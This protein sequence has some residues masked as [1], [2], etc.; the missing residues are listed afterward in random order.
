MRWKLTW[1]GG[2]I[3]LGRTRHLLVVLAGAPRP[4]DAWPVS[5]RGT[6]PPRPDHNAFTAFRLMAAAHIADGAASANA[7]AERAWRTTIRHYDLSADSDLNPWALLAEGT[8]GQCM[9]TAAFVEAVVDILGFEGG[10]ISY[11]YPT[12]RRP[13]NPALTAIPNPHLPGAFTVEAADYDVRGQ[14][15]TVTGVA[16]PRAG[17]HSIAQAA[18]HKG[19][20]GV[21]RLKMRDFHGQLHN[22]A[23]AFV[24]DEGGTRSYYGGGYSTAPYHSADSFLAAACTAVVWAYEEGDSDEWET[25]CNRPGPALEWATGSPLRD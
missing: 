2:A 1:R 11:V 21:E 10:H 6:D 13:K 23:T 25:V 19:A 7:A 16:V 9:T 15:R 12:L 5:G 17:E 14:F 24:V 18:L 8:G 22:Y 4:A 20:H 3:P